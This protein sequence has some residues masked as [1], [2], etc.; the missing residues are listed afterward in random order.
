M[1]FWNNLIFDL[2][3]SLKNELRS[4]SSRSPLVISIFD[5]D[6]FT[7]DLAHLCPW[8]ARARARQVS[9]SSSIS[10]LSLYARPW[11]AAK[12]E[13]GAKST[14][15]MRASL[16]ASRVNESVGE[17]C[18]CKNVNLQTG[19]SRIKWFQNPVWKLSSEVNQTEFSFLPP[20][21]FYFQRLA[22]T[23]VKSR[24]LSASCRK[25]WGV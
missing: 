8:A 15:N 16:H 12:E 24:R 14:A 23:I 13:A 6:N 3:H 17:I 7:S 20:L 19:L 11:T 4:W 18:H 25:K 1:I 2:D 22:R 5:L 21:P 9:L 10:P